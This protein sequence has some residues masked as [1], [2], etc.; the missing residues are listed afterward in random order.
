MV[1][2]QE[3]Y[4]I[5]VTMFFRVSCPV[6]VSNKMQEYQPVPCNL[7]LKVRANLAALICTTFF[8]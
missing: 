1:R 3:I 6:V 8:M 2:H 7:V 5:D 4:V